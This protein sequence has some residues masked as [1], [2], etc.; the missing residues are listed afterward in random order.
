[1]EKRTEG[2]LTFE[3]YPKSSLIDRGAQV[4][5]MRRGTLDLSLVP[6]ASAVEQLPEAGIGLMP[7][8]VPSYDV[9]AAWKHAD[10]GVLLSE[11]L[12]AKGIVVISWIWQAGGIASRTRPL[13]EP[14]DAKGLR[15]VTGG[16]DMDVVLKAAGASAVAV[17][18]NDIY[19]AMRTGAINAAMTSSTGLI[20]F[21]LNETAKYLTS[22]RA[23]SYWFVLEPL[24][25]SKAVFDKLPKRHR[26]VVMAVGTELEQFALD[27]AKADDQ[28]META[29]M[30]AGVRVAELDAVTVAKWQTIARTHAWKDFANR[31]AN[32]AKLLAAAEKLL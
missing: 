23:K 13:V 30:N 11:I 26:D 29:F 5:A 3:V 18:P 2:A 4:G 1:M 6:L 16:P 14:A 31:C 17:P 12:A 15:V 7:G 28:L 32:C 20:A 22:G 10:V 19:A 24:M 25:M 21:R 27:G 9:A 8:L